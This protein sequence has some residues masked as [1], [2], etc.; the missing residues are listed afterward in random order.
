[1]EITLET[2]PVCYNEPRQERVVIE[3]KAARY[4][5]ELQTILQGTKSHI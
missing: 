3:M 4:Q 1:M 2:R 5:S